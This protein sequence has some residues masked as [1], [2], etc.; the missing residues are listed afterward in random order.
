[1]KQKSDHFRTHCAPSATA[2]IMATHRLHARR[3]AQRIQNGVVKSTGAHGHLCW[4]AAQPIP[5]RCGGDR[6]RRWARR[7]QG[8]GRKRW[9]CVARSRALLLP[10]CS[11][12]L[13]LVATHKNTLDV[14]QK[15][16]TSPTESEN[17]YHAGR[18]PMGAGAGP[19]LVTDH[20]HVRSRSR[21]QRTGSWD[22][23]MIAM[24]R[25]DLPTTVRWPIWASEASAGRPI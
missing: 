16:E 15:F 10:G 14:V 4:L 1:M 12:L 25:R 24:E 22:L 3:A 5:S 23:R 21:S 17:E 7:E 13:L 11:R 20:L 9:F 8:C 6:A 19:E 18:T 2:S